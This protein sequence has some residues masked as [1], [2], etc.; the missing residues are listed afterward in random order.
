MRPIFEILINKIR[1]AGS[2]PILTDIP[3]Q[4]L[5]MRQELLSRLSGRDVA[6]LIRAN[7]GQT[8]SDIMHAEYYA[9][10]KRVSL[11]TQSD[12]ISYG[13]LL[14]EYPPDQVFGPDGAHP[15]QKGHVLIARS[16]VPVIK[17]AL[18]RIQSYSQ[19]FTQKVV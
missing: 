17:T 13:R 14:D 12:M 9:A 1:E 16:V 7:G 5:A 4:N 3:K 11:Q 19:E 18:H 6:A 15:S 8:A 2:V 10:A